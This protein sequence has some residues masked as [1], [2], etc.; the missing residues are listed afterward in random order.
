MPKKQII[1]CCIGCSYC[2]ND[3][4][5]GGFYCREQVQQRAI[6]QEVFTNIGINFP[7]WCPLEDCEEE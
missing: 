1:Y 6:P 4:S 3:N 5:T 7:D 2:A